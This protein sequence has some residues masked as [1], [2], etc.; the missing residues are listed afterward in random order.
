LHDFDYPENSMQG[1]E[2]MKENQKMTFKGVF[3]VK[4][5]KEPS[6]V[7]VINFQGKLN[8]R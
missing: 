1:Y 2:E 3:N 4:N 6:M 5:N 8:L 7:N